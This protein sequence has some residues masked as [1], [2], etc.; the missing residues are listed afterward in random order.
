MPKE[1][2][3]LQMASTGSGS[4][5]IGVKIINGFHLRESSFLVNCHRFVTGKSG[6]CLPSCVFHLTIRVSEPSL[7]TN[8]KSNFSSKK[9]SF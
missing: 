8:L 4:S 3:R 9:T 6:S 5:A 2:R 7:G 1:G